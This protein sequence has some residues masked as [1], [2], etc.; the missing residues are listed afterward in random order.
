MAR[1]AGWAEV[2]VALVRGINVAGKNK[3]PMRDL[4]SLFEQ[5]GVRAVRTYIQ[6]GN[7][8]FAAT[9]DVAECAA[10]RVSTSLAERFAQPAPVMLRSA[11]ELDRVITANPFVLGGAPTEGLHVAF[12]S[13]AP[14]VAAVAKLDP[15]RSP[16]DAFAVRGREVFLSYPNGAGRTKLSNDYLERCLGCVSTTRNL[17]TVTTL[18]GMTRSEVS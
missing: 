11:E 6:S 4:A 18:A 1:V 5:A 16:P 12:L 14:S 15:N 10:K 13:A 9:P 2:F 7:V 3:L 8:V 17:R